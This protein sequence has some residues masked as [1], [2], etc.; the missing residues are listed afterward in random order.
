VQP[1]E[2]IADLSPLLAAWVPAAWTLASGWLLLWGVAAAIPILIHLW[3]RRKQREEPWA[4]MEFLLA[5]IHNQARRLRIEQLILL[6]VRTLVLLLLALA[7]AEPILTNVATPLAAAGDAPRVHTVLVIDASYSMQYRMRGETLF[8]QAKEQAIARVQQ[9]RQGDGFTVILMAD[10]PE[11]VVGDAAF[12]AADVIEQ[13]E[14]LQ[15]RPTGADLNASLLS[16]A[17]RIATAERRG[18]RFARHDVLFFSDLG[19]TTWQAAGSDDVRRTFGELASDAELFVVPIGPDERDNVAISQLTTS[20]VFAPVGRDLS[21][22]VVVSNWTGGPVR[23]AVEVSIDAR[24]IG[25]R[26]LTVAARES[27]AT[28]FALRTIAPGQHLVHARI[29][30]DALPIDDQRQMVVVAAD[31]I[32][33]LCVAGKPQAADFIALALAPDEAA[34]A[35]IAPEIVP[36][37]ALLERDLDEFDCVFLCNV[38]RIARDEAEVLFEFVHAGGGLV[39]VLGDQVN[40]RSYNESLAATGER[41]LLPGRLDNVVASG[42]YRFVPRYDQSIAA[43]FRGHERAGLLT[44]PVWRYFKLQPLEG[45]IEHLAFDTGDPAVLTSQVGA[46]RV[47]LFATAAS[48]A[49]VDRSGGEIVPWTALVSWPSFPPL[50]HEMLRFASGG[51][52]AARNVL[53]GEALRWERPG[54]SGEPV[55]LVEPAGTSRPVGGLGGGRSVLTNA[56]QQG[57]Y[58]VRSSDPAVEPLLYVARLDARESDLRQVSPGR[59]PTELQSGHERTD[60]DAPATAGGTGDTELFRWALAA[61]FALALGESS[62]ACWF[63]RAS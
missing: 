3:N 4:A 55:E 25:R 28:A 60:D 57:I 14:R 50:V 7:L 10:P 16:V 39:T 13:I 27:V 5:A 49:S 56:R 2:S 35:Q 40:A 9:A 11:T 15:S 38:G 42:S 21:V 41:Q 36:E 8:D 29:A 37:S 12:D 17:E 31:T 62:L 52:T 47:V 58:R 61:V 18:L 30:D 54:T 19:R 48:T 63:G 43:P 24:S 34:R 23:R 1:V 6:A 51:R 22:E 44:T 33:V 20:D 45:A 59:L 26:E 46:G 53:V 32:R